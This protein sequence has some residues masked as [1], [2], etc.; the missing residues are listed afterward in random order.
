MA[1]AP[2]ASK[3]GPPKISQGRSPAYPFISLSEAVRRA[4]QIRDAGATRA[5][6]PPETF[7]QIWGI[8]PGSSAARQTMA[9]LNHFDLVD[10]VGRGDERRVKLSELALQIVLDR[11]PESIERAQALAK[12][13]LAPTIHADLFERYKAFLPADVVIQT[14][15]TRD[16]GYNDD[17]AR[18]LIAEYRET[19]VFSGLTD[20]ANMPAEKPVDRTKERAAPAS[21]GRHEKTQFIK[22]PLPSHPPVWEA[23]KL[24][25]GERELTTGLLS[26]DA[27][28][29][30]ITSGK[31]GVKEIEMLIKKLEIDKEILAD[32]GGDDDAASS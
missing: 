10:Y 24:M 11:Q 12:A 19:L 4:E 3:S 22:P 21:G 8:G 23:G 6:M 30:L 29:R 13:A 20:P 16:K 28:F 31:I 7:Y 9:A 32:D 18:S 17:A 5:D 27:S 26:K 1:D 25:E 15:L 2:G 14:Y